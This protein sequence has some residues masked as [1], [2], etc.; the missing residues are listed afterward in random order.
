MEFLF[1]T[2]SPIAVGWLRMAV[3]SLRMMPSEETAFLCLCLQRG[4]GPLCSSF[5]GN[6]RHAI[7]TES[8]G[9]TNNGKGKGFTSVREGGGRGDGCTVVF[10]TWYLNPWQ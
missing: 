5:N 1:E 4:L 7:K 8:F 10:A 3:N 9:T 2:V 6:S